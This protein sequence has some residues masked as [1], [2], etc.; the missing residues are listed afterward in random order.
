M[1]IVE[2]VTLTQLRVLIAVMDEGGIG[3]A[4]SRLGLA[5]SAVSQ[6]LATLERVL[7]LRLL[8]RRPGP[9]PATPTESAEIV[10]RHA[11]AV[12]ER[13][14]VLSADVAGLR[15]GRRQPVRLGCFM[16]VGARILPGIL[17]EVSRRLERVRVVVTERDGDD[18]LLDAVR[19]GELDLAFTTLPVPQ[20]PFAWLELLRDPHVLVVRADHVLARRRRAP[21]LAD[22][23]ELD[24]IGFRNDSSE[25][26]R[27]EGVLRGNGHEPRIV[28]RTDNNL[29][30]PEL[31]VA[32]LGCAVLPRLALPS[33]A[34]DPR[35]TV[36][37]L[38]GGLVPERRIGLAWHAERNLGPGVDELRAIAVD[39]ASHLSRH[40]IDQDAEPAGAFS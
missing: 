17:A 26:G 27:V 35:V 37:P 39:V 25:E 11:R 31:I 8:D 13:I 30:I 40:D 5:Q 1:M 6:H 2:A 19:S 4:A 16:S 20:G 33:A 18:E 36:I 9:V 15:A 23:A 24:L 10:A 34:D 29:A 14:E 7:D 12:L 32:G 38:P 21:R 22:L 3:R 28:L